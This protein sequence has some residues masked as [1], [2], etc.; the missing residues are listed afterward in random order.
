MAPI[1][2]KRHSGVKTFLKMLLFIFALLLVAAAFCGYNGYKLYQSAQH[3]R[4]EANQAMTYLSD[5][6]ADIVAGD[7]EKAQQAAQNLSATAKAMKEE[8]STNLWVA[9]EKIPVYGEDIYTARTLTSVLED[10]SV[11]ALEPLCSELS[12][13]S[14]KS[15]MGDGGSINVDQITALVNKMATVAPVLQRSTD[16]F[17]KCPEPH[18]DQLKGVIEKASKQ[19]NTAN[20]LFTFANRFAPLAP[21]VLGA[22]GT[23]YYLVIAQNNVETRSTG[24]FYG[25]YGVVSID[26]GKMSI[27][28]FSSLSGSSIDTAYVNSGLANAYE[29]EDIIEF[30]STNLYNLGLNPDVPHVGQVFSDACDV[31]GEPVNGIVLVDPI[32]VQYMIG[33]TGGFTMSDGTQV[34]GTNAAKVIMHDTYWD[35]FNQPEQQDA[36]FT[37]VASNA[38]SHVFGSLGSIDLKTLA[39]TV[40]DAASKRHF[41]LWFNDPDMQA[42][43]AELGFSGAISTDPTEAVTGVYF[44]NNSWS[45][46]EWYLHASPEVT[47]EV[48][49]ADGSTSYNVTLTIWNAMSDAEAYS[50]NWY[51]VGG[52]EEKN[53]HGNHKV[54]YQPGDMLE[55]VYLL[56]PAGGTIQD[57]WTDGDIYDSDSGSL[58]GN[59]IIREC[60]HLLPGETV[61]FTYTVVT[62][63]E[64]QGDL[65]FDMTPLAQDVQ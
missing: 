12:G 33:L 44:V 7:M 31:A 47:S 62:S 27:S 37:M 45:K 29:H 35:Y 19:L 52:T 23:R 53:K 11:N 2:Q 15:L 26:N 59:D 58:Y 41:C 3:V 14:L 4:S 60:T 22:N 65:K 64:A 63:P 8:T 51:V 30:P 9:A 17:N 25:Q 20:D 13:F 5:I 34:D 46:M 56:A 32:F 50:G 40:K 24:G 57:V 10:V 21:D 42:A 6:K 16:A 48:K 49:N 39:K 38:L 36:F 18:L 1:P 55:Y 61:T 28:N 54:M 43:F